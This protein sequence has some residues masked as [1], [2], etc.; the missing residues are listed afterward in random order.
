MSTKPRERA[1]RGYDAFKNKWEWVRA[2][3]PAGELPSPDHPCF[4]CKLVEKDTVR[5]VLKRRYT[6]IDGSWKKGDEE[7]VRGCLD[8]FDRVMGAKE[9]MRIC[10]RLRTR[11]RLRT[12]HAQLLWWFEEHPREVDAHPALTMLQRRIENGEDFA[13]TLLIDAWAVIKRVE[14]AVRERGDLQLRARR[15]LDNLLWLA[16]PLGQLERGK[17]KFLRALW[18]AHCSPDHYPTSAQMER[19]EALRGA[20]RPPELAPQDQIASPFPAVK[21]PETPYNDLPEPWIPATLAKDRHLHR[22]KLIDWS[23]AKPPQMSHM[24]QNRKDY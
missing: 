23:G 18:A 9:E 16:S 2:W 7:V 24:P 15:W 21:A 13:P 3:E 14:E 4:V 11:Q 22:K 19:V 6:A 1:P 17:S 12:Q 8:C 5:G 20:K 10:R